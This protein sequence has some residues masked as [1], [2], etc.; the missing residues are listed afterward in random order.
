MSQSLVMLLIQRRE[1]PG[2]LLNTS[3]CVTGKQMSLLPSFEKVLGS[4]REE[5]LKKLMSSDIRCQPAGRVCVSQDHSLSRDTGPVCLLL[6]EH[7]VSKGQPYVIARGAAGQ[8]QASCETLNA[9]DAGRQD[10]TQC[11]RGRL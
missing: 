2:I 9:A 10:E 4:R 8:M 7:D 5:G 3:A 6:A 1:G 11:I